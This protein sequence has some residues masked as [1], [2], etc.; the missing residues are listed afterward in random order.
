MDTTARDPI[1]DIEGRLAKLRQ[2]QPRS[3]ERFVQGQA[4]FL[5]QARQLKAASDQRLENYYPAGVSGRS[6]GR[7]I[8]WISVLRNL[9]HPYL[10][11][12]KER[13]AMFAP[14]MTA[15]VVIVLLFGGAGATAYAAQDSL[16]AD[17]LY[18]VKTLTEDMQL[19]LSARDQSRLDLA[20]T[21]AERR[22]SEMAALARLG[23]DTPAS[24]ANR[25]G[26][27]VEA[28]LNISAGLDGQAQQEALGQV[29]TRMEA[30]AQ[31]MAGLEGLKPGDPVMTQ[32]RQ[33]L[34]EQLRLA[35]QGLS[36]PDGLQHQLRERSRTRAWE[37]Q[38][39]AFVPGA[40][41]ENSNGNQNGNA[42]SNSN[43][44]GNGNT[45][46]NG[47][48]NDNANG[49]DNGNG[50]NANDDNSNDDGDDDDNANDN[51]NGNGNDNGN[52]G[53]DDCDNC[54]GDGDDHDGDDNGNGWNDGDHNDDGDNGGNGGS[55]DDDDDDR[56]GNGNDSGHD[57]DDD[58]RG[59]HGGDDGDDDHGG[60]GGD[61][62]HGG[63][64]GGGGGHGSIGLMDLVMD[65][66]NT[67]L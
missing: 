8:G 40:G 18:P 1:E 32:A 7:L 44:N 37:V 24:V 53:D 29:L 60:N 20:L 23:L 42:N 65:Y 62:D 56:G 16:P 15:L 11:L 19:G 33:R 41:N 64:G 6:G 13:P 61:D 57:D 9:A 63:G 22:V 5:A 38:G 49:D 48:T 31:I 66:L 55:G 10:F 12:K 25:M 30:Q 54:N 34:Q 58:D 39:P 36:D 17:A 46:A 27:N 28:A 2:T 26:A 3:E 45:N 59:G 21:F 52:G 51:G 4:A 43:A 14:V 47:N 67:V 35:A 50:D